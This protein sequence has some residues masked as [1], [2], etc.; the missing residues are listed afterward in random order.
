M[1]RNILDFQGN[2]VGTIEF[3]AGT[4]EAVINA[5]LAEMARNPSDALP[6]ITPRQVRQ[7]LIL[8]GISI[9]Q[10]ENAIAQLP[11]PNKSLAQVEWEYSIAFK[12]INPLVAQIGQIVGKTPAEI[13]AIWRLGMTL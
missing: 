10:I 11:E 2:I 12:R 9:Q 5:K 13:D 8:S 6:D 3:P 7:A 1:T 4:P